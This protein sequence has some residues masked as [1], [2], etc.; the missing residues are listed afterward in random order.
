MIIFLMLLALISLT[1]SVIFGIKGAL[2]MQDRINNVE[3]RL[4][5]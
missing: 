5:Q 3:Q 1:I 4:N 2:L